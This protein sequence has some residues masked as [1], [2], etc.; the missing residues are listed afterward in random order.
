MSKT[1][2]F[3]FIDYARERMYVEKIMKRVDE[4]QILDILIKLDD[5][6]GTLAAGANNSFYLVAFGTNYTLMPSYL[7]L[8]KSAREYGNIKSIMVDLIFEGEDFV[9]KISTPNFRIGDFP[10]IHKKKA[11]TEKQG[12][13]IGG[14]WFIETKDGGFEWGV[15]SQDELD[16]IRRCSKSQN[17]HKNWAGEMA[18]KAIFKR[19]IKTH[20]TSPIFD[21]MVNEDN[22]GFEIEL[23]QVEYTPFVENTIDENAQL[24]KIQDDEF[25]RLSA[26]WQKFTEAQQFT[27]E[28]ELLKGK[29]KEFGARL[30]AELVRIYEERKHIW[31]NPQ[32]QIGITD[33]DIINGILDHA[34]SATEAEHF[35]K[36]EVIIRKEPQH[37]QDA[38][39]AEVTRLYHVRFPKKN[40]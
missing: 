32:P 12:E 16:K 27:N 37:I 8:V 19:A 11:T 26:K 35:E 1:V 23:P 24:K 21:R 20:I 3:N 5:Y 40:D 36:L 4:A 38:V 6:K 39:R 15:M 29:S 34:A 9:E 13:I 25:A 2:K 22:E 7:A 31:E 33:E 17:I 18:K 10:F 30:K 14:Y 28:K